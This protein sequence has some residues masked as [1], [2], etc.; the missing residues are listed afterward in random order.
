MIVGNPLRECRAVVLRQVVKVCNGPKAEIKSLSKNCRK[1][2]DL[3][4][5]R[6]DANCWAWSQKNSNCPPEAIIGLFALLGLSQI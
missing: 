6:R 4:Q 2:D 3:H 1:T 5:I